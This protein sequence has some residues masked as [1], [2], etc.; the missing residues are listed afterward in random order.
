MPPVVKINGVEYKRDEIPDELKAKLEIFDD[1]AYWANIAASQRK[2]E[3][4][5]S[6]LVHKVVSIVFLCGLAATLLLTGVSFLGKVSTTIDL[7]SGWLLLDMVWSSVLAGCC[8]YLLKTKHG[9][10]SIE[11]PML[12]RVPLYCLGVVGGLLLCSTAVFSG[13]P[14]L[15]HYATSQ[16]GQLVVTVVGKR[17]RGS[18]YQCSPGLII[19]EFTWFA[20]ERLCPGKTLFDEIAVGQAIVVTG[21]VSPYGIEPRTIVR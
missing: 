17:E 11:V 1:K 21:K 18:R 14:S 19:R 3:W 2:R 15:M 7:L 12:K 16:P 20:S 13:L 6:T 5:Q 10:L 9:M 8:F 4:S